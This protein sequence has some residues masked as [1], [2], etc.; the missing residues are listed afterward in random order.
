MPSVRHALSSALEASLCIHHACLPPAVQSIDGQ[1]DAR[2]VHGFRVMPQ[3][4]S[5]KANL[6]FGTFFGRVL[7]PF[8]EPMTA[9]LSVTPV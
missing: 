6:P 4:F 1:E 7:Y 2:I 9:P 5:T 3:V 8:G